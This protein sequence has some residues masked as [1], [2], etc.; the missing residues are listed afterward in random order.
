[1]TEDTT[2]KGRILGAYSK[3]IVIVALTVAV[4]TGGVLA[5]NFVVDPLWFYQGNR[6]AEY[7]HHYNE[8]Y[9][10]LKVYLQDPKK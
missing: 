5:I 4:L 7:N 9:S 1:M 10:K 3:Y 8:R 6:L 2:E